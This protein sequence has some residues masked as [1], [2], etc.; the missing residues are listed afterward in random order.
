MV[1]STAPLPQL[2]IAMPEPN[3]PTRTSDVPSDAQPGDFLETRD[4]PSPA[5]PRTITAR[6]HTHDRDPGT[7]TADPASG[8]PNEP[9]EVL[10][11]FDILRELGSGGMGVVYEAR[12]TRLNRLVALKVLRGGR[13]ETKD[14][15]RFLAEAEAVAAIRHPHVVQVY[16]T[17]QDAGRP[18]MVLELLTGGTLQD[19][20]RGGKLDPRDA[21]A[22]VAKL[23]GAVQAA[24]EL[25]I[26]HRDLKP[27]NVLMASGGREPPDTDSSGGSRPPLAPTQSA[28]SPGNS[29]A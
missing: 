29:P 4:A 14:I 26:V 18:Y 12:Q 20:L 8:K 1:S 10:P 3:D 25:G 5:E 27:S 15:V 21:A 19:R 6:T 7:A 13:V 9:L 22:L 11:G 24:H 17:N 28:F 16:E 2:A 23:A